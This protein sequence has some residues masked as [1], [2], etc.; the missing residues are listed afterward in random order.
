MVKLRSLLQ[1]IK[2]QAVSLDFIR[3]RL[4]PQCRAVEYKSLKGKHRSDV[5]KST[6][7][8]VVLIPKVGERIG[9]FIVLLKR[10]RSIEYFS[11]LGNNYTRELASLHEPRAIFDELLGKNYTYNRTQLQ[12]GAYN[13]NDC[14]VFV[15][16]RAYFR[17]LKNREFIQLFAGRITLESSDDIAAVMCVALFQDRNA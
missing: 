14:S 13:I 8:L 11:S 4:P 1:K 12:S 6:D 17:Q 7:A 16:L 5:F 9:H 2:E 15:I 10:P 3:D